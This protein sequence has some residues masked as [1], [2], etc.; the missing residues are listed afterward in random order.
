MSIVSI[1]IALLIVGFIAYLIQIAPVPIHPWF[2]AA[3]IGIL[4]IAT[5][6]WIL[7]GMGLGTGFN[8][9]FK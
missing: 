2:K 8:L 7:N 3:I 5:I 4:I 1:I 6:I 9:R